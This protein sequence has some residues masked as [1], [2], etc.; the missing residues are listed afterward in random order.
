MVPFYGVV[1]ISSDAPNKIHL[2]KTLNEDLEE[3][4][5]NKDDSDRTLDKV[6]LNFVDWINIMGEESAK[7]QLL[8]LPITTSEK[9]I[10]LSKSYS[11]VKQVDE[12]YILVQIDKF[13]TKTE[14]SPLGFMRIGQRRLFLD[15]NNVLTPVNDCFSILDFYIISQ[16][17]GYGFIL[18]SEILSL[19]K[20][21]AVKCAYDKPSPAMLSFLKKNFALQKP[22][23]QHNHY[24]IFEGFF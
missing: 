19:S 16:R 21:N 13:D 18:F 24:V 6:S 9:F 23:T 8:K 10:N 14:V 20:R 22:L 5:L 17:Q 4:S 1:L 3:V 7:A 2:C 11:P 12:I 15:K